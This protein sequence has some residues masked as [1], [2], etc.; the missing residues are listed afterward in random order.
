MPFKKGHMINVGRKKAIPAYCQNCNKQLAKSPSKRGKSGLC[1]HCF[2]SRPFTEE[3]KANISNALK[4]V[5]KSSEHKRAIISEWIERR[6]R[7]KSREWDGES[8][9]YWHQIAREKMGVSDP[10]L[11][12]HHIDGNWRNNDPNNLMVLTRGMHIKMHKEIER[13]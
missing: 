1:H 6:A 13:K 11:V 12:V 9:N 2:V 5:P 10:N 7:I 4:G 3:H 8:E